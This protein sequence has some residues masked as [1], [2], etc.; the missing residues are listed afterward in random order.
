MIISRSNTND[1]INLREKRAERREEKTKK[2]ESREER[3]SHQTHSKPSTMR[4][5][6][7]CRHGTD[8]SIYSCGTERERE[9]ERERE[10][11]YFATGF[12][13]SVCSWT[14]SI[15]SVQSTPFATALF[16]TPIAAS[17]CDHIY[18]DIHI[19]DEVRAICFLTYY[20]DG[21]AWT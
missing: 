5:G 6:L 15:N 14:N 8:I 10:K 18:S 17:T 16:T 7:F 13:M 3:F 12:P 11:Y 4:Q 1:F 20:K 2:E 9:R 19:G 21:C